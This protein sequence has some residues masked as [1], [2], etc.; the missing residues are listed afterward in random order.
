MDTGRVV[1]LKG[2]QRVPPLRGL[3]A[4]YADDLP[5]GY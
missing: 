4:W 2:P 1:S 3:M 5:F